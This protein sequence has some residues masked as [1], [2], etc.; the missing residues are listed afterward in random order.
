MCVLPKGW[1]YRYVDDNYQWCPTKV[2]GLDEIAGDAE[3]ARMYAQGYRWIVVFSDATGARGDRT[4]VHI[5][6]LSATGMLRNPLTEH[7]ALEELAEMGYRFEDLPVD[8]QRGCA[9]AGGDGTAGVAQQH[10]PPRYIPAGWF[11]DPV[12]RFEFRWWDGDM[13]SHYVSTAGRQMVD[14]PS[15]IDFFQGPN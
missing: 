7:D 6:D 3:M 15:G 5:G 12:R 13:W 14:V 2:F 9:A 8:V 11:P 10:V 1:Y 4:F